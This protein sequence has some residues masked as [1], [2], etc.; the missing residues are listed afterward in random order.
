VIIISPFKRVRGKYDLRELVA[1]IPDGYAAGETD[2]GSPAGK[3][4]W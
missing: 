3:E 2:W 4:A 1:G